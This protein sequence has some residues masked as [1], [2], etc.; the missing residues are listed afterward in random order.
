ML[1]LAA[2]CAL[3]FACATL[4]LGRRPSARIERA[5]EDARRAFARG[6]YDEVLLRLGRALAVPARG[7]AVAEL[8]LEGLDLEAETLHRLGLD[9]ERYT[10]AGKRALRRAAASGA[11]PIDPAW[12]AEARAGLDAGRSAPLRS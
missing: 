2:A 4:W 1:A 12:L 7:P 3:V 9:A 5:L 6:A 8:L 10:A 11:G